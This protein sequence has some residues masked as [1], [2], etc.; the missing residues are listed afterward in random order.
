MALALAD[1]WDPDAILIEDKSSGSSLIQDLRE[2]TKWPVIAIE[3]CGD[4]VTRLDTCSPTVEAGT[5]FIPEDAPWLFDFLIEIAN[6]PN[7][8][9]K[10]TVDSFSQFA[11]WAQKHLK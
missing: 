5:V 4:K 2:S 7:V 3:P 10:D 1:K 8:P 6:F 9:S 11:I